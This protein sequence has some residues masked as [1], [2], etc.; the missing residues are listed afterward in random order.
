MDEGIGEPATAMLLADALLVRHQMLLATHVSSLRFWE[1]HERVV[2][3]LQR[4]DAP[5]TRGEPPEVEY[6]AEQFERVLDRRNRWSSRGR[7][8]SISPTSGSG[9]RHAFIHHTVRAGQIIDDT[10]D[11]GATS[12]PAT[13]PGSCGSSTVRPAAT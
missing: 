6:G 4:G 3:G 9:C 13:T 8:C 2:S 7:R 10:L 1:L 11:C 5:R 12:P